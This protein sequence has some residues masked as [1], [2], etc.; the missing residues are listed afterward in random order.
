ML[1]ADAIT[2][3]F[4]FYRSHAK[5]RRIDTSLAVFLDRSD[6]LGSCLTSSIFPPAGWQLDHR[7]PSASFLIR[8]SQV[9]LRV[10]DSVGLGLP[11]L[12]LHFDQFP[13][14]GSEKIPS[15]LIPSWGSEQCRRAEMVF[16]VLLDSSDAQV[17]GGWHEKENRPNLGVLFV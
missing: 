2:V 8:T 7:Q 3:I 5:N 12:L 11:G 15:T 14:G 16:C 1:G 9:V 17:S 10:S 13:P 4:L 6:G